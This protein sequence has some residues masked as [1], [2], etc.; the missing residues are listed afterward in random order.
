MPSEMH[1]A[2]TK[3]RVFSGRKTARLIHLAD[4]LHSAGIDTAVQFECSRF[5]A[6]HDP[7]LAAVLIIALLEKVEAQ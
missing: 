4:Q 2:R 6:R 7:D 5:L 3:N 1:A